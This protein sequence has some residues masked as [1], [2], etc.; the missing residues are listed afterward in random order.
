VRP[1]VAIAELERLKA[2]ADDPVALNANEA[3]AG[4]RARAKGILIAAFPPKHH[5]AESFEGGRYMVSAWSSSTPDS[6]WDNAIRGGI[7][8]ARALLDAAIYELKLPIGDDVKPMD[9][10]AYDPEL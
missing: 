5:L 2:E 7:R 6:A 3:L 1:D 9:V 10:R 4:W 8:E